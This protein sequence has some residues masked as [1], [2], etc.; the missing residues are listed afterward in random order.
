MLNSEFR[1]GDEVAEAL[2]MGRPVV[3]LE[4]T[5]LSNLGLP[6]PYNRECLDRC[7]AAV[8]GAGAVPAITA[9]LDGCATVG[10]TEPEIDRV[11]LG[12]NKVSA[13]DVAVAV[14]LGWDIG[15]TTVAASVMLAARAGIEVFATGG[16]G[17]VHR[18]AELTGD[19]SADLG[20]LARYPVVT[21]TAGAK[22]FLDLARTVE[23]FD[24][25]GVPL[26]GYGTDEFPAFYSR[27]SGVAVPHRVE[28][29]TEV[30][31]IVGAMRR[32][33]ERGGVVV[34]NPIPESAEIP[35]H[36]IDLVIAAALAE[37]AAAGV[38]G[39]G[40]TPFVL[41]AIS[42][43]TAGRSIPANLAL[44]EHNAGVAADIAVALAEG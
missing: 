14:G 12:T 21:V 27:T 35:S 11:L 3:A 30:A 31:S 24:T 25:L 10:L 40:V 41:E 23:W 19:V 8:R 36:E 6:S 39:P 37:A 15:V 13:R 33:G 22:A 2:A 43:A 17:G 20:A 9:V 18:G 38:T 7:D 5:I 1:V 34:A 32:A 42:V 44:A 26:L 16:I 4:S 29:A 28:T